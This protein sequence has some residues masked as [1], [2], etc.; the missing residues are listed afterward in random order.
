MMF[1]AS[2]ALAFIGGFL[3][4]IRGGLFEVSLFGSTTQVRRFIWVAPTTFFTM[5]MVTQHHKLDALELAGLTFSLFIAHYLSLVL[6]GHGA[7]MVDAYSSKFLS[8]NKTENLTFWLPWAFGG[9]PNSTWSDQKTDQ[10]NVVGMNTIGQVRHLLQIVPLWLFIGFLPG[11]AVYAIV[12]ASHG[13]YY[14][15]SWKLRKGS[16]GGEWFV[17]ALTW[18]SIF[19]FIGYQ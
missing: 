19:N 1:L 17:G 10:Y 5:V 6:F 4:R 16:Q 18:F 9:I 13:L 11:Y 14:W 3:Y 8:K 15:L 7:H 12:G 2:I